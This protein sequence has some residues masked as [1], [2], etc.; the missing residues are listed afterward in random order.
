MSKRA[1]V[2]GPPGFPPLYGLGT[3]RELITVSVLREMWWGSNWWPLAFLLWWGLGL[4]LAEV[5]SRAY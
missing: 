3:R 5:L 1:K 2:C 4:V